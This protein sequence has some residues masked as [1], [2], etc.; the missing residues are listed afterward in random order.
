M[1]ID[2]FSYPGRP[3]EWL[4]RCGACGFFSTPA[5]TPGEAE[6]LWKEAA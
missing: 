1:G 2:D 3:V 5:A 4:M 6:R